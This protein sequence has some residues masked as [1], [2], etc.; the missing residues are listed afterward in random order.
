VI[1]FHHI[2]GGL[3]IV[4]KQNNKKKEFYTMT[5]WNLF[6]EGKDASTYKN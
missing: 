6:L 2:K 1:C 5:K 4:K 3:S